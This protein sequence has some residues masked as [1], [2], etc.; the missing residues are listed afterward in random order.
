MISE[1]IL[2][3]EDSEDDV[4]FMKRA[5]TRAGI[6]SP[7]QVVQDGRKAMDYLKGRGAYADRQM[8]PLPLLILL[9]LKLP[10]VPGLEVLKWIRH[11]PGLET[12][13]VVVLTSSK[14]STDIDQAYRYGA[15][16]YLVKP[17]NPTQLQELL[18]IL[19]LYWLRLNTSPD[20]ARHPGADS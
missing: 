19:V 13:L 17:S 8:H 3:V 16:S 2:L 5:K 6:Q 12:T 10:F 14:E 18:R 15:N 20:R 9:D 7:M 1:T 4:L 11:E